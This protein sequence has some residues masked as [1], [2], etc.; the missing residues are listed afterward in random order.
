MWRW[1]VE[2]YLKYL[3][4]EHRTEPQELQGFM[5]IFAY[6]YTTTNKNPN[7]RNGILWT[8]W[9]SDCGKVSAV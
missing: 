8:L 9:N 1:V 4:Q 3:V 7:K 6:P 2:V 5:E